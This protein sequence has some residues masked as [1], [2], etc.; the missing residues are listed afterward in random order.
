MDKRKVNSDIKE[1]KRKGVIK[2]GMMMVKKKWR[3]NIV[4]TIPTVKF[5]FGIKAPKNSIEAK[6]FRKIKT[7]RSF[8]GMILW[9][10]QLN[11]I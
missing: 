8:Y 1:I 5:Y 4:M 9:P 3:L 6:P 10:Y 7:E 11:P 2:N